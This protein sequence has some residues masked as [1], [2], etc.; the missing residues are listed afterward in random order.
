MTWHFPLPI[1]HI[2]EGKSNNRM[3]Q[4]NDDM[5]INHPPPPTPSST[6]PCFLERLAQEE[7]SPLQTDLLDF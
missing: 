2:Q 5:K 4:C 1:G 6:W 3:Q 7:F